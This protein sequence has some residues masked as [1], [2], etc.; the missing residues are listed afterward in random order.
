M[1]LRQTK[2]EDDSEDELLDIA[3][4]QP[5]EQRYRKAEEDEVGCCVDASRS[6]K[7]FERIHASSTL[8]WR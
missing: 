7:V 4:P 8:M 1:E 5:P 2:D 3:G 6:E